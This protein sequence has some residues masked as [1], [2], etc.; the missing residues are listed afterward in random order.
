MTLGDYP[1]I[2]LCYTLVQEIKGELTTTFNAHLHHSCKQCVG[3]R[4]FLSMHP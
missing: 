3:A 1:Y 4:V 2:Y